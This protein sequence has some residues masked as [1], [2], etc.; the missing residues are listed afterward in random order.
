MKKFLL[1]LL[2]LPSFLLAQV[3]I[4]SMWNIWNDESQADSLRMAAMQ[5]ISW[6]GYIATQPDSAFYFAQ[7]LLD[8][9]KEKGVKSY[10]AAALNT[11]AVASYKQSNYGKAIDYQENNLELNTEIGNEF[12]IATALNNLG[13]FHYEQGETAKA[14]AYYNK[15]L[16]R[17]EKAGNKIGIALALNNIGLI[18][19]DQDELAEAIG[20]FKKGLLI[21]EEIGNKKG[22]ALILNN[23]GEIY[24]EQGDYTKAIKSL[25][26]SLSLQEEIGDRRVIAFSL[27]S[28]GQIYQD[29]GETFKGLDYFTT[30]LSIQEEIG[31]KSGMAGVLNSIGG[32]YYGSGEYVKA[33]KYYKRSLDIAQE[34]NNAIH[35]RNAAKSLWL[36]FK[37][38]GQFKESLKM[39]E[40]YINT[41]DIIN[42]EE[43]QKAIIK[44]E[45]KIAYEK[46]AA[47]D[48]VKAAEASKVADALLLAER[49]ENKRIEHRQYFLYAGLLLALLFG[50]IIY[51]RFKIAN[52][53]KAIIAEQKQKVDKAYVGLE[54][55]H[56]EIT[57]SIQ[58]A[59]RI[60]SAILPPSKLVKECLP[61]SFVLYKPKDVVAGDFYWME[62]KNGKVIFAAGDCTGHGVPGAM[63]SVVC[64][65]GLNRSVREYG[66]T[67]PGE[68][69]DKTREIV[70]SEFEKSE[71]D[72]Q[73]GMDVALFSLEGNTLQYAGAHNPLWLIRDGEI[74]E[75]KA[76]KQPIGKYDKLSPFTTHTF[77]LQKGDSIYVFSDG[78]VDQFGGKKEKKFKSK[79]FK[80]LLISIQDQSM[81][82]QQKI[83][84]EAFENWRGDLEQVDD[85]CVIGV[86]V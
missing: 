19:Q 30:S 51:N 37:E 24:Q 75:T 64:N 32:S 60:Q 21:E 61:N 85:V 84:D 81:E 49:A 22:M 11:Q 79:A 70:I 18:Y 10:M 55:A 7:K 44:Q 69:L 36:V 86:K 4:D 14:M 29:K 67:D 20:Y 58:Y 41:R 47:A 82:D 34:I 27:E 35:T 13:L 78:F 15:S 59:K 53:Q 42:S 8:F 43:N 46:Q 80:E 74:I 26:R 63:V 16:S 25:N 17:H 66:L 5:N 65:N 52:K 72:V 71:D 33:K 38:L 2:L 73:D 9:A 31:D 12:G 45:Y 50:G 28:L 77:E 57:D 3:K 62:Q 23:L 40:L 39:Y 76:D 83:V 54:V 56:K 6:D 48:S 1:L 68:I